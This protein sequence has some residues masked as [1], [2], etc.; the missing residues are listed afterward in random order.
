MHRNTAIA[1]VAA[2]SYIAG[3][4]AIKVAERGGYLPPDTAQRAAQVFSGVALAVYSNAMPKSV[5][6]FRSPM[7]AMRMQQVL[8]VGGWTFTVGGL[9]FAIASLLPI[10]DGIPYALLSAATAYVLGYSAKAFLEC[11]RSNSRQ[12]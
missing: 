2:G 1:L 7:A 3:V 4:F 9:A 12:T 11:S 8:R 5:G 10:H 6:K